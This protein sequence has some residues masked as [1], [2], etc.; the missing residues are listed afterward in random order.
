MTRRTSGVIRFSIA[1]CALM[2]ATACGGDA[3]TPKPP[4]RTKLSAVSRT[5]LTGTVG[6]VVDETPS[7]IVTD[8][9]GH[10]VAGVL[11]SFSIT[12]GGGAVQSRA[13]VSDSRGIASVGRWTLG[14]VPG[15]YVLTAR[16]PS[17]ESVNFVADAVVGAPK[18][19]SKLFGDGQSGQSGEALLIRPRVRV[20]DAWDNPISAV[21][22]TFE[23]AAGG[24]SVSGEPVL[25]DSAGI[26]ASGDWVLGTD[27]AQRLVARVGSLVT[28]PFSARIIPTLAPC[29]ESGALKRDGATHAQL[30][31]LGCNVYTIVIETPGSYTFS[32]GSADFDTNIQLR[33]GSGGLGEL[34]GNDDI[35]VGNPNSGFS[36]LLVPGT[37]TLFVSTSKPGTGGAFDATYFAS[38][39]SVDGCTEAFVVRGIDVRGFAYSGCAPEADN[40]ADRFRI[41]FEAGDPINIEVEDW[42]YS[43][44]NIRLI[45]PDGSRLEAAAGANYLTTLRATA[46]VRGY[47]LV[48]VGLANESGLEYELRIR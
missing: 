26:A 29:A 8:S 27:G 10:P 9:L 30:S 42:S 2:L 13:V 17:D 32:A 39:F 36:A 6:T 22:V 23:V 44:P 15:R 19:I 45:A 37:Y 1:G 16:N 47:Y 31:S 34:A 38:S 40:P 24:G 21:A 33:G 48:I 4:I 14:T 3:T 12:E 5:E 11:I 7:V 25:T 20:S 28:E 46:P 41:F 35:A 43:G 18:T